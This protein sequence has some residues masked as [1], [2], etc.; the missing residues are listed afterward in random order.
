MLRR[1]GVE[2]MM[3]SALSHYFIYLSL[4]GLINALFYI[5][6]ADGPSLLL[7]ALTIP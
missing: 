5:A 2:P 1:N 6:V 3:S 4:S 7:M